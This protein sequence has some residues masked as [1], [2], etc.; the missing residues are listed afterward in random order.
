[1]RL[2]VFKG[3]SALVSALVNGALVNVLVNV[4]VNGVSILGRCPHWKVH[5]RKASRKVRAPSVGNTRAH[6]ICDTRGSNRCKARKSCDSTAAR[7]RHLSA[8]S[9][10]VG[11]VRKRRLS[12]DRVCALLFRRCKAIGAARAGAAG[13]AYCLF[14]RR[15]SAAALTTTV[16]PVTTVVLPATRSLLASPRR[17]A[18]VAR[19]RA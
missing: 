18:S 4:L 2:T 15:P 14:A 10:I 6:R 17:P 9:E 11:I 8:S 7:A 13:A 3:D 5:I 1:M 16:P 19:P 12:T